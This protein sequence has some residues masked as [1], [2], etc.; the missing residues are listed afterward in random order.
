MRM[1]PFVANCLIILTS[2]FSVPS[3]QAQDQVAC[4]ITGCER[5]EIEPPKFGSSNS[6]SVQEVWTVVN[7]IL[8]VSGLAPNFQVLETQEIGNAAALIHEEKRYLA[9]NPVWMDRYKDDPKAKWQLYGVMAHEV[10]HHLQGHTLNDT[11]SRPPTE[12]EADEYAGFILAALGATLEEAQSL[13]ATLDVNA[14][15]THPPRH[16]RLQAV[17]RGWQRYA[18]RNPAR[19]TAPAETT[20]TASNTVKVNPAR[21][22]PRR[23][24]PRPSSPGETCSRERTGFGDVMLCG[25]SYLDPQSGNTYYPR[26]LVDVDQ[27]TAWVEGVSGTGEG[28]YVTFSFDTPRTIRSLQLENGY[29]KSQKAFRDN[30]SV[31]HLTLTASNGYTNVL[32]LENRMGLQ[33]IDF[34]ELLDVEWIQ[35]RIRS[36]YRGARWADT[37][38]TEIWLK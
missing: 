37:A 21:T 7:D 9:F 26:N 18:S 11:G 15:A 34:D 25:S 32:A 33:Q 31:R 16:Q 4:T 28:E 10:G 20:E 24:L 1:K 12:L 8:S 17:E 30:A 27:T 38:I 22:L 35:L 29:A 13:W 23:Q 36:T 19:Q 5:V 3:A 6:F 2:V 14:T